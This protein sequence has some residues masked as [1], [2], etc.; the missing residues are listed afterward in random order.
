[1]ILRVN[2][3]SSK[4]KTDVLFFNI[5]FNYGILLSIFLQLKLKKRLKAHIEDRVNLV[6]ND[7]ICLIKIIMIHLCYHYSQYL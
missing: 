2:A 4:S 1:M 5:N 3:N 6:F 7:C